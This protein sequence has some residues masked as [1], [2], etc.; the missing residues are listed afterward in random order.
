MVFVLS[1]DHR[2]DFMS[3]V[4]GAPKFLETPHMDRMAR[5]GVRVENTGQSDLTLFKLF[6]RDAIPEAAD[7]KPGDER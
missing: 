6:G 4:P 7:M 5:E 2:Y 3:C 1:D